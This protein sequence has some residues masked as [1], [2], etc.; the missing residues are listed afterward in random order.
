MRNVF[1]PRNESASY[2]ERCGI[3]DESDESKM[4]RVCVLDC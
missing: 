1:K 3:I 2:V 4:K